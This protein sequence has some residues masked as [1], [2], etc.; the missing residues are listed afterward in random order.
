[1][2]SEKDLTVVI[3][4]YNEGENLSH[5]FERIDKSLKKAEISYTIILVDDHSTDNTVETAVSLSER[6]PVKILRKKENSPK[7]K[8]SSLLAGIS[9][10]ET[11]VVV[12]I[13]ADL[14]YPPEAIPKMYEKMKK[15]VDVVVANRV[16]RHTSFLRKVTSNVFRIFF[17][18]F[19]H[20]FNCDVQSGL[21][22]FR[23]EIIE[24]VSISPSKWMF[25]LEFLIAALHGGYTIDTIRIAFGPRHAGKTKVNM[26]L[27]SIEMALSAILLKFRSPRPIPFHRKTIQKKGFGF[28]FLGREYVHHTSLSHHE[29]AFYRVSSGQAFI[30]SMIAGIVLGGLFSNFQLT[31]IIIL[32]FLT[33]VYFIDFLF[34]LFLIYRSFSKAPEITIS[35]EE[36]DAVPDKHWPMYTIFCPLYKEWNVLPQFITAITRI[37]YPQDKLQVMLLLEED[38]KETIKHAK[39]MQLPKNFE[40]IIVPHSYPKT[41]PKA[42]NYG[43]TKAKGEYVVIYDAEDIPDPLQLKKA[44]L[45]FQKSDSRVICIQAKLNFYNPRQNL[46]TR[47]F[48]A[49]Y[50]LWFDLILTGLQSI[51]AP[52]PLGGTSN[53]FRIKDL[54]M[55]QGWDAFNVT[56]DCDLGIRLV[57][58]GYRTAI[59]ESTTHEEANSD[60]INWFNQ[61][62]RWIKGYIQTYLVH[63]RNPLS[64]LS[65]WREPHALTFQLVVGGKVLALFINPFMWLL[66][67]LYFSFRSIVG[68]AI[69]SLYPAPVFYMAVFSL[70]FGN[71]LYMYY[72]MIGCAKREQYDLIKYAFL[73]PIYWLFMSIAS[74][75]SLYQILVNPHYWAKTKHGFHLESKKAE[76][77]AKIVVG[78]DLVDEKIIQKPNLSTRIAPY[79]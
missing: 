43:L 45:A 47:L 2:Q 19:L 70:I 22:M 4:A 52:I 76:K 57:R 71:F 46:L 20:G 79:L 35:K 56:E 53:H 60:L 26:F 10:A 39:A 59:I 41:K 58:R 25:D 49:E 72:Y 55:L 8:A 66:T 6:Y 69:E 24:R 75:R 15:G 13:D 77:Q 67:I 62:S 12:M 29:T 36:I 44:V 7:G 16:D 38:D 27:A 61:R 63:M 32:A 5:L 31:L 78:Q 48:T 14:Q 73:V 11:D 51:H 9:F 3:P 37:D 65:R 40:I 54:Q 17:G 30:I 28:H 68:P 42:I 18:K 23:K 34:N 21:K 33:I 74:W 50:S 64:F 1:M